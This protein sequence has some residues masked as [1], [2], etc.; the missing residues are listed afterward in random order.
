[1]DYCPLKNKISRVTHQER[2]EVFCWQKLKLG[3]EFGAFFLKLAMIA[4]GGSQLYMDCQS[5]SQSKWV[6]KNWREGFLCR[7]LS[8]QTQMELDCSEWGA[9]DVTG[10]GKCIE[11]SLL[12][13]K[14][15]QPCRELWV[16]VYGNFNWGPKMK[17]KFQ[18]SCKIWICWFFSSWKFGNFD[19]IQERSI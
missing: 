19:A 17:K 1:M 3:K 14:F 15:L 18:N 16:D 11:V 6:Q 8:E 12:M 10:E 4:V 13:S 7:I 9:A 5:R 2:L